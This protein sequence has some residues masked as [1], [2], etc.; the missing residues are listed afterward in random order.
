MGEIPTAECEGRGGA[1]QT[2]R[3]AR[4]THSGLP[5]L[6]EARRVG[7]TPGA[8]SAAFG[9]IRSYGGARVALTGDGPGHLMKL[10]RATYR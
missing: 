7:N 2:R 4:M 1:R 3:V 10:A 8:V 6:A 9:R 5:V